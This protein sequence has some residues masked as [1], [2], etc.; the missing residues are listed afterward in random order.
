[1]QILKVEV[2]HCLPAPSLC[3]SLKPPSE[4]LWNFTQENLTQWR[5]H[6]GRGGVP[7]ILRAIFL[8]VVVTVEKYRRSHEDIGI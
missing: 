1:M 3:P 6:Q 4:R 2:G 8:F 5:N 7:F